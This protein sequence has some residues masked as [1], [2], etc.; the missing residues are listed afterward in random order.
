MSYILA[1]ALNFVRRGISHLN[2]WGAS[3]SLSADNYW[4]SNF[5]GFPRLL[6]D[7]SKAPSTIRTVQVLEDDVDDIAIQYNKIVRGPLDY[8]LAIPG[9][10]IRSKLIDSF[11][12]WLQLPEE[13]LSIV[14][15]IINLLHTASLLIDDIQDAS[16]LRRGKPV[17]HD[18]Y[19]VA[20]TINSANYAY[21]LQQ[22]RLKEIGDPRAFEIFTRSLLDLHLGQG[23]DLY[24]RDMVVCP[25][26]EEYTRMVMYKTGGLFNLALDLMRIQ[27]RKNTDFSKLVELLGVIF[28]IRDDYMNLQS[29]L[30]AEKK[31]L[32]EDLT[33]G[34]FSYPIIHSIRASPESSELLDILKQRTEDE[35]VKI[36]AV[37]I[38]ESTGSFQYTRETLSRLSAEARGY[39]KKLET[40]LGPNPGIHK[41]LD[42]LEVEYP[43]NEKGRV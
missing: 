8:L 5:Q 9:K 13:K 22:A 33:E 17:A 25:T 41:I 4:E 18:V 38:M 43:T 29:G 1:E 31:G 37:K 42:L 24:W 15:D 34:K 16:R 27:S 30:Y 21:Y 19:G 32:M 14:K 7:S 10:D 12:I 28:Q 39:V 23:M 36:R 2:Y 35:A 40:S 6:S 20:Q 3:H 11:N 26:E